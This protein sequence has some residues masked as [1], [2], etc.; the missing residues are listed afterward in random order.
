MSSTQ[1]ILK[2]IY[3]KKRIS[4]STSKHKYNIGKNKTWLEVRS[5]FTERHL[6]ASVT[7]AEISVDGYKTERLDRE[8][9]TNGTHDGVI[10][11]IRSD[12]NYERR[13][14]LEMKGIE[15][16][17]IEV[18]FTKANPILICFMYRPPDSSQY[19]DKK[20]LTYFDN[21]IKTVD[22]E[23]KETILTGDLNCN[24]LVRNDHEEIKEILDRNKLKQLIKQPTRITETLIDI[25]C[26]NNER[27]ACDTI[28]ETASD[29]VVEPSAIT[30]HDLMGINRK[31][32]CQ[33]YIPR[34]LFTRDYK[35]Y[36]ENAYRRELSLT[37]W[38][39]LFSNYD[40]NISWNAF[41]DKLQQLVNIHASLTEKMI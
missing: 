10:C 30:N 27:T 5:R 12:V 25:I 14:N 33:K 26:T 2:E 32:N 21:M 15:A 36:D 6:N 23:N 39:L 8:N 16:I 4:N 38:N 22:Y 20:F 13:R 11:F 1:P 34:K 40:F 37:D 17:W 35:N 3:Q 9:G 41:K 18:S 7:D 24:Y 19:L 28:V 29:T 31:M